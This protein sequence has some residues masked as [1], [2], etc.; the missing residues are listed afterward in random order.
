MREARAV[1]L[2]RFVGLR[3]AR[4]RRRGVNAVL[5]G[6]LALGE[7]GARGARARARLVVERVRARRLPALGVEAASS[8]SSLQPDAALVTGDLLVE[9]DA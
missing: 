6:R 7:R 5:L 3:L 4:G 1:A 8:A 9:L 2:H